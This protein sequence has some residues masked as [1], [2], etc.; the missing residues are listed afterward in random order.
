M[1]AS[2]DSTSEIRKYRRMLTVTANWTDSI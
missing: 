2:S 1:L